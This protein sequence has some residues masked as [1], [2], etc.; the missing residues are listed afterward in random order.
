MNTFVAGFV[1]GLGIGI[2]IVVSVVLMRLIG[3]NI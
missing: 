2:G 3:V 1:N